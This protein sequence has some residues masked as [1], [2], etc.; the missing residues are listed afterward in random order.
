MLADSEFKAKVNE[1][2]EASLFTEEKGRSH[3]HIL[4]LILAYLYYEMPTEKKYTVEDILRVAEEYKITRILN[5]NREKLEE[6]LYEMWDLNIISKEDNFYRFA[7]EGFRELLGGRKQIEDE[8]GKYFE[9][10]IS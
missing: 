5:I 8:M 10:V 3:Y 7:T 9:E 4:A 2:L 6:L 1:K